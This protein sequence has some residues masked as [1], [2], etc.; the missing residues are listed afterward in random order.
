MS[1]W[2]SRP[3]E[4]V[5]KELDSRPSGLTERESA[6]RLER[7]GPNQLEPPRKPSVLA[8][9]LGQLKDPMILVLLGAAALSLAASGGEDWLD[10][11][12]ILI[13]VLV[14]GV[15]SIT[16][17]DHAQHALEQLRR[18]SAPMACALRDGRAERL[19]RRCWCRGT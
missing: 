1:D 6:Q 15:I 12:I 3:L 16:Q 4:Q 13:I 9:V 18:M 2:H 7:L 8:R 5:M 17:E 11:A 14:N 19:P 10:G